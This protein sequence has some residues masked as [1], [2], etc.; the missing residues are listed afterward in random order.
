VV[1]EPKDYRT[2]RIR[3]SLE[4]DLW[5]LANQTQ[6]HRPKP[7]FLA[8]HGA[9]NGFTNKKLLTALEPELTICS[10]DHGNKHDH[11]SEGIRELLHELRIPLLTTKTGDVIVKS[12]DDHTGLYRA[13]NLKAGSTEISSV[14][15]FRAKKQ[16]LLSY[17]ADTI[18]QLY[19][20][21]PH[22]RR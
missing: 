13:I 21:V 8:H 20:A 6:D 17:N 3:R 14:Y 11:P 2:C 10:S 18:R 1:H 5:V 9:D 16:K 15:D 19:A 22:H 7:V 4:L 12:T